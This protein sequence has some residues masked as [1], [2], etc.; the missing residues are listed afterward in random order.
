MIQI[1]TSVKSWRERLPTVEEVRPGRC[2]GC[3]APGR[4]VGGRKCIHGHGLRERQTLG[5]R[6]ADGPPVEDSILARRFRCII[7]RAVLVVVP[8]GV[9]RYRR[10][11]AMAIGYAVALFGLLKL[12]AFVVR[13]RTCVWSV[14]GASASGRW[15]TLRR[16]L[17]TIRAGGLFPGI[18]RCPE[19]WTLRQVAERAGATLMAHAVPSSS[20]ASVEGRAFEGA[21]QMA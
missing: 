1:G 3:G 4:P 7:C 17:R 20:P 21:M 14:V 8:R 5:P 12:A 13:E 9:L 6:N 10:Y 19:M 2:P 11:T 15:E 16:W 18:R